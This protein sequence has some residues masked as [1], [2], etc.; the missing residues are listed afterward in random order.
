MSYS[1]MRLFILTLNYFLLS[2]FIL[3]LILCWCVC[4][5]IFYIVIWAINDFKGLFL[6]FLWFIWKKSGWEF[7]KLIETLSWFNIQC[8]KLLSNFREITN[9]RIRSMLKWLMNQLRS[10]DTQIVYLPP[11]YN[12]GLQLAVISLIYWQKFRAFLKYAHCF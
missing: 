7:L 10:K 12:A 4:I 5:C 9:A 1:T 8:L 3:I 6:L 11:E 2:L